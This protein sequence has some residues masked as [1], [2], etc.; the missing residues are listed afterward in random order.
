MVPVVGVSRVVARVTDG[1]SMDEQ[2]KQL[3]P[4]RWWALGACLTTLFMTLLDVN[5]VVVALPSIGK[6]TG[7]HPSELQW[8]I[9]GYALGVRA[10]ADHRRAPRR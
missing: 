6:S 9:S 3:D 1:D 7:A 2:P 5:I 8:V 4:R 10:G